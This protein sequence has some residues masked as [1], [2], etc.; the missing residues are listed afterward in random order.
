MNLAKLKSLVVQ[1]F[2]L[3]K[4]EFGTFFIKLNSNIQLILL[5]HHPRKMFQLLLEKIMKF[6]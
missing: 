2:Q 5:N 3:G 4:G 1:I 6:F